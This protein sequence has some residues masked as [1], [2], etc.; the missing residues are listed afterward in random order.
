M[1]LATCY[2]EKSTWRTGL[3]NRTLGFGD[4]TAGV[5]VRALAE[6]PYASN[7]TVFSMTASV[8]SPSFSRVAACVPTDAAITCR[9]SAQR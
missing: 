8:S 7:E 3:T 6:A 9:G 1:L 2:F 4:A 5:D